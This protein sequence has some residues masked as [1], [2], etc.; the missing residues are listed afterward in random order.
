MNSDFDL[1]LCTISNPRPRLTPGTVLR[2][3]GSGI[4]QKRH[5]FPHSSCNIDDKI[6]YYL[7][8]FIFKNN[9]YYVEVN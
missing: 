4:M 5:P 9:K 1:R 2:A 3:V 6:L 8:I 7:Q